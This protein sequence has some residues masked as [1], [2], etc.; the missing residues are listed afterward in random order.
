MVYKGPE[1]PDTL[2]LPQGFAQVLEDELPGNPILRTWQDFYR[3]F[4]RE[5]GIWDRPP[6]SAYRRG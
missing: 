3:V 5:F 1:Q 4:T 2:N 6:D